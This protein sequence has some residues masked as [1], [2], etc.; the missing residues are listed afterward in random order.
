MWA[1]RMDG[2]H[3]VSG[4]AK[5]VRNAKAALLAAFDV[6]AEQALER[7][8]QTHMA[9]IRESERVT[10]AAREAARATFEKIADPAVRQHYL[11]E[12]RTEERE[13]ELWHVKQWLVYCLQIEAE[14]D[15]PSIRR[16]LFRHCDEVFG[17]SR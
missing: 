12:L 16:V 9:A 5:P 7:L 4:N 15:D 17:I 13:H 6:L 11:A 3:D 14:I 10:R 8:H 1:Q 2:Y